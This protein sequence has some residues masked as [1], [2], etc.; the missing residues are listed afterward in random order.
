MNT[1]LGDFLGLFMKNENCLE[2]TCH[3]R[4]FVYY[5]YLHRRLET[6]TEL[7]FQFWLTGTRKAFNKCGFDSLEPDIMYEILVETGILTRCNRK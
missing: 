4:S 7:E 5:S 6:G 3:W 1:N 2:Y